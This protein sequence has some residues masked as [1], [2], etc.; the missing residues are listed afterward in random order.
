MDLHRS[1]IQFPAYLR[2]CSAFTKKLDSTVT[3]HRL[4]LLKPKPSDDIAT[5]TQKNI[6]Y[7]GYAPSQHLLPVFANV[8]ALLLDDKLTFEQLLSQAIT[9]LP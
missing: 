8:K 1:S 5:G 7:I 3:V 9:C 4:H 2:H 6:S